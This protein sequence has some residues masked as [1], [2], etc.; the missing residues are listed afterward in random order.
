MFGGDAFGV[1]NDDWMI[2]PIE[3]EEEEEEEKM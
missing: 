3:E 1:F 2:C